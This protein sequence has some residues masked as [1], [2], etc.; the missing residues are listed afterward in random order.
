MLSLWKDLRY[1]FRG[2]RAT[3]AFT[4]LAVLTLALG[5][6]AATTMF[7][8]IQNVL[9]APFPYKDA[10]RIVAFSVHNLDNNRGGQTAFQPAQFLEYQNQSHV[11]EEVIGGGNDE[12][13]P[14]FPASA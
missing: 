3:P 9:I 12:R 6:G 4:L 7:S 5:I 11:F 13:S 10:G 14:E 2:L 8:V 1:G